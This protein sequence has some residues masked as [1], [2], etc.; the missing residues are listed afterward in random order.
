MST[1]QLFN[2]YLPPYKA[3]VDAGAATVMSSF[4]S[5]NGVPNTANPYMLTQILRDEWGFNGTTLSD[6][7]A[8]QELEDFGYASDGED[9]AR[10]ALTAGENIEMAVR[11]H[12]LDQPGVRHV[13]D[14]GPA[15]AE[16][17][18]ITMSQL[19][20]A[21]RHVLTLKYL[22]GMFSD[23]DQGNATRY[24]KEELTPGNLGAALTTAEE[25][26]V[27]LNNNNHALPL[28]P[29]RGRTSPW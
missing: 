2:D 18:Q 15:A 20:D 12:D 24:A 19:N 23:P 7:Q 3:A 25:S 26:L 9:A 22:A 17:R 1:Q 16:R 29:R 28:S 10:L 8:V 11:S 6:Y 4:N 14:V 5:L 21:V 27:L 13:R